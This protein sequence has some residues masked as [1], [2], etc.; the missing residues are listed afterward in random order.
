MAVI[1]QKFGG[2]SVANTSRIKEVTKF[3]RYE[4]DRGNQVIIIVSA[5]AGVTNQLVTFCSE[6]SNLNSDQALAEY[7][8]VLAS[9]EIVTAGLLALK[10]AEDNI[11]AR[12]FSAW[13]VPIVTDA[14]HTKALVSSIDSKL[15]ND[16]LR[17]GIT[18]V[19]TGFQGITKEARVTTLG[20]GGSDTTAMLVAAAMNAERCDIYTDV[21]GVFT[22]DPRVV[23]QA[24]KIS[25]LSFE[26]MLE[27]ASSGAKVLH[28]RCVEVGLR[29]KVPIRVLSSF[30]SPQQADESSTLITATQ[31]DIMEH[32][33]ITAIASN[34]NLL[35]I[36][37]S[38]QKDGDFAKIMMALTEENIHIEHIIYNNGREF[39]FIVPLSEKNK[40]ELLL[41]KLQKDTNF[42]Q[43]QLDTKIALISLIGYGIK[44]DTDFIGSIIA[45]LNKEGIELQMMQISEVKI[46]LLINDEFTEKLIKLLH[47]FCELGKVLK[48]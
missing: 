28:P 17:Q 10:L 7:D 44:N 20:R 25:S 12:S 11:L 22:A 8:S 29:Y 2:T 1:V 4:L 5:M 24:I 23:H 26:E 3:V 16:C 46:S 47:E 27:F 35:K 34:K 19:I 33:V 41:E 18:P 21:E 42:M 6:L 38:Y 14:V 15:L 45:I 36:L 9:G 31:R 32:R 48:V 40:L 43:V 39:S 30:L 37:I 13:Q